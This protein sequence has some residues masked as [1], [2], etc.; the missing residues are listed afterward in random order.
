VTVL[1]RKSRTA[2]TKCTHPTLTGTSNNLGRHW[3]CTLFSFFVHLSVRRNSNSPGLGSPPILSRSQAIVEEGPERKD[4]PARRPAS[5]CTLFRQVKVPVH[6]AVRDPPTV[7]NGYEVLYCQLHTAFA[8]RPH[9]EDK[10]G[11]PRSL[12]FRLARRDLGAF[13]HDQRRYGAGSR[14]RSGS[15]HSTKAMVIF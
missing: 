12:C 6:D 10:S 3:R 14:F 9:S 5:V 4:S 13:V 8:T 11:W 7:T 1:E 15:N 2:K